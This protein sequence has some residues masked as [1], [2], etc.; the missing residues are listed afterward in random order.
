MH[1]SFPK[2]FAM[3]CCIV[4]MRALEDMAQHI[5]MFNKEKLFKHYRN[6]IINYIS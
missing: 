2:S 3:I 4:T 1:L 5:G 6:T